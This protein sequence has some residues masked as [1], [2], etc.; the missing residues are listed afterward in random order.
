MFVDIHALHTL[1]YS[2]V[3]RDNLGAPKSCW[4][5]GTE[6]IRVSSQAW[7]RAIRKAVEQ[8]LEQP[9]E[10]TR[11]I[12]SLVAGI[13]TE[14]GWGAED[15][16][17]AGRA[18]IYA[19]GLEPAADD[20]DTDTLLWTPPAAEALAGVV[21]KH[22][23]TVVTLPLPKGEGKKA[24][25][26]P[27][28]D[29]TDAVKPMA[30]EVKSILN[31]TTPTIALLGRMLADR[32]DHTIYGLAEIAH[33]FTVHEAAPEFDYFT[34]VDDRA[35][36]TGAG[37]VNTAQFTT[38]TFYRY[39]SI[40]ITR[41]VDVVGEQ[42]ARAVLLAWARRFITVT[43]AGKQTATAARTAADLAHIV[44]RNAPQS[45][46][47]AFETPIVSTGGYLDPAA[48][49]LGDYATRLAAYLGDTPV[50]H[51]YATTLPTNVDGLGGRF[52]TLDTLIN[53]TVGAVA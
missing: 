48:R 37:H 2:N 46:A 49:A 44:V 12:A 27:A 53:A 45:Y 47:P 33:A 32:P 39:S 34:A 5:G 35:A 10:R 8:D 17:R 14:R 16:R 20:D 31:R 29:I 22:R 23:D 18:V 38:G 30:G 21:E 52:D 1:P 4:Y 13:L 51:G 50:E 41:L 36:N 11:R 7:K 28:K 15:A 40:N 24:K 9:T 43:P 3:N 6:R 26:P 25:N 42:D 19:Y